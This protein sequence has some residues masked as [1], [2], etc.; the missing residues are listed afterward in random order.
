MCTVAARTVQRKISTLTFRRNS[1]TTGLFLQ[2][3]IRTYRLTV[4][5]TIAPELR[6]RLSA[7]MS[8]LGSYVDAKPHP[9]LLTY[10]EHVSLSSVGE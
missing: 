4:G 8:L 1:E 5:P 9:E 10:G 2:V 6:R 3:T 7:T